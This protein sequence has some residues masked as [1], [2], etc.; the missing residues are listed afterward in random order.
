MRSFARERPRRYTQLMVSRK[1]QTWFFIFVALGFLVK[2]A[3]GYPMAFQRGYND[4]TSEALTVDATHIFVEQGF[5]PSAG[6]VIYKSLKTEGPLAEFLQKTGIYTHFF[7]GP[8]YALSIP[9]SLVKDERVAIALGRIPPLML[10]FLSILLFAWLC[11]ARTFNNWAWG[12]SILAA[13][14]FST[15]GIYSWAP[16]IYGHGYSTACVFFGLCLGLKSG[17]ELS[18]KS[19][20][21]LRALAFMLGFTVI[22][23]LLEGVLIAVAAPLVGSLLYA[24]SKKPREGLILSVFVGLGVASAF[25]V[26]F[27]QVAVALGSVHNAWLDQLGIALNRTEQRNQITRMQMLGQWSR[28]G[29][30]QFRVDALTMLLTGLFAAWLH[31]GDRVRRTR[32]A[33][34]VLLACVAAYAFPLLLK[35]HSETHFW[36]VNRVFQLLLATFAAVMVSL[37][38]DHIQARKKLL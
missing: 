3:F 9:F 35:V 18:R 24:R 6:L 26:H 25:L 21:W 5:K 28:H 20:K 1:L 10:V 33:L 2:V 22:Y 31:F 34:A 36:R 29:G 11:E 4:T 12:K 15:P 23:M 27:I 16:S 17:D 38:A 32:L 13:W 30:D 37:A 7:P 19:A 8:E 14:I